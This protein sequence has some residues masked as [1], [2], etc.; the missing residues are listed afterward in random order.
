MTVPVLDKV[1]G[2]VQE[3]RQTDL[4][5]T[6]WRAAARD[7]RD[8]DA[9]LRAT[10]LGAPERPRRYECVIAALSIEARAQDHLREA[11]GA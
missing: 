6:V 7:V 5:W 1:V 9:D 4:L 10:P 11:L 8:A 3:R 2:L